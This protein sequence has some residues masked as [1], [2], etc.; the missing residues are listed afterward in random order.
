MKKLRVEGR[1]LAYQTVG[2]GPT[3]VMLHGFCLDSRIW[4]E[5]ADE[6]AEAKFQ[7]LTIDLPGFG[8][9]E[10]NGQTIDE[11]AEI[12]QQGLQ[13]LGVNQF[14]CLG[15][16]MGGYVALSMGAHYPER[17]LGLG[18]LHSHPFA[19]RPE[20]LAKRARSMEFIEAHGSA[21]YVKQLIPSLFSE[22]YAATHQFLIDKLVYQASRYPEAAIVQALAAM[23]SRPDRSSV[24]REASCPVLFV[25]GVLDRILSEPER[26]APLA[27]PQ[28]AHIHV[29]DKVGHMGLQEASREVQLAVR[30]FA[31]ACTR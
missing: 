10:V 27:M 11:F 4:E 17:L 30:Q 14:V 5:I 8:A 13:Q 16:S 6:L 28:Q 15:H 31:E 20:T 24:L 1:Q 2:K 7:A 22:R 3:I 23:R 26:Q 29:F 19:D 12:I 25:Q 21:L 18:L 9:S